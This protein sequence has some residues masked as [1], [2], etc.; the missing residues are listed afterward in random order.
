MAPLFL[1]LSGGE[2]SL[3]FARVYIPWPMNTPARAGVRQKDVPGYGRGT[4]GPDWARARGE[5]ARRRG[6]LGLWGEGGGGGGG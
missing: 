2:E 1:P 3:N 4:K 5:E 6:P